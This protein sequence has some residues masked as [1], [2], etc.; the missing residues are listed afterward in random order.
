MGAG[1]N[2]ELLAEG[3]LQQGVSAKRLPDDLSD[4]VMLRAA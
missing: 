3:E 4:P 2:R 1:Y